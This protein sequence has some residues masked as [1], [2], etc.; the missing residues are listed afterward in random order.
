MMVSNDESTNELKLHLGEG[1]DIDKHGAE[2]LM[3]GM[4]QL[5]RE[6]MLDFDIRSFGK[7][8]E[9]KNYA[10]KLPKI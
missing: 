9:P 7:H 4:R 6:Y 1:V 2:K 5:A 8:I 10:Y 3:N